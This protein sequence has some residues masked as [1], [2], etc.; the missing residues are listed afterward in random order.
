MSGSGR[1]EWSTARPIGDSGGG[2]GTSSAELKSLFPRLKPGPKRSPEAAAANQ[3]AR[4]HAAMIEACDRKGYA[5]TTAIEVTTLAGV[6]KKTLY[7]HFEGKDACFLETYDLVIREAVTRISAAYRGEIEGREDDRVGGGLCRAFDAFAAEMVERPARSRIALVDVL[8]VAPSARDRIERA[9]ATFARMI[10]SSLAQAPDGLV[11]P[12]GIVRALIGGIWFVGRSRLLEGRPQA[13]RVSGA[14]LGEWLLAYR[15]SA[16][17]LPAVALTGPAPTGGRR[18]AGSAASERGRMLEAA[19]AVVA[20]GGYAALSPGQVTEGADLDATAFASHFEDIHDCFCAMLEWLSASA[21]AEALRESEAAPSW[22]S[23]ICRAVD[24][25]FRRVATDPALARAAFLDAFAAGTATA[26]HRATIMRGFA[27][28]LA[29]RAP[30]EGRPNPVV[31]EAIVGAVWS[32][33]HRHV[34]QGRQKALPASWARAAFVAIA[35]IIGAEE[36]RVAI[37][38]EQG[39]SARR[40]RRA[41]T[42]RPRS[43]RTSTGEARLV[44]AGRVAT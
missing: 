35:P 32:I 19:A 34:V 41:A 23:G 10:L 31:A 8:A 5:A 26:E 21:L 9:E 39:S 18:R 30:A 13:I 14:E 22:A 37:L 38:A 4:L 44:V 3:R 28:V 15:S 33:A 24:V 29:R 2:P 40:L 36:A 7:K 6:S 1:G 42:E 17:P 11:I 20:R 16:A 12:S 27:D 43:Y 25:L